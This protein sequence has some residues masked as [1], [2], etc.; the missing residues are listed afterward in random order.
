MRQLKVKKDEKY[1][2]EDEHEQDTL[3]EGIEEYER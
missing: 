2:I 1:G 3:V